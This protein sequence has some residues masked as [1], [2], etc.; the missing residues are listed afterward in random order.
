MGSTLICFCGTLAAY[1]ALLCRARS[2]GDQVVRRSW[3]R[4]AVYLLNFLLTFGPMVVARATGESTSTIFHVIARM[5]LHANGLANAATYFFQSRYARSAEF[6]HRAGRLEG[7]FE[8][9]FGGVFVEDLMNC[10]RASCLDLESS[11]W[12]SDSG[13]CPPEWQKAPAHQQRHPALERPRKP[14]QKG[15]EQ[16]AANRPRISMEAQRSVALLE[17]DDGPGSFRILV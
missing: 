9:R 1:A 17:E 2:A 13:R 8:V 15:E 4:A 10:S 7:S 11:G 16:S 14:A 12:S 3:R 6:D 5:C